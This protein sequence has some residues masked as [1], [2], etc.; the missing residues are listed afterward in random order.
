MR[1]SEREYLHVFRTGRLTIVGFTAI[2]ALRPERIDDCRRQLERLVDEHGCQ[3]LIVDLCEL[4][5][6]SS[7][8]LGLLAY[9]QR[10]GTRVHLYHPSAEI[11]DILRRTHL[12]QV[13]DVRCELTTRK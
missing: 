1:T 2:E 6:V 8:I 11:R 4:P 12:D 3:D 13:L 9:V 7:W 10:A 5:I